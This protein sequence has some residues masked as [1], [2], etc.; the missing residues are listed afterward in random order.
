MEQMEEIK[1]EIFIQSEI[2]SI[3]A[4]REKLWKMVAKHVHNADEAVH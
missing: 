2:K 1:P 3:K 4:S